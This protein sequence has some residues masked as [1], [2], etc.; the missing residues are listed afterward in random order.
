MKMRQSV[1][2]LLFLFLL[3][4]CPAILAATGLNPVPLINQPLAPTAAVPGGAAF[5]LTVN[6]TGFVSGSIVQWNGSPRATTFV[7]NSQLTAA[8]LASD[9]T[10]ATT[11]IVTVL[12]PTPG[13][14]TS[15]PVAFQVVNATS[16]VAYSVSSV[17]VGV[18]T[19]NP[20]REVVVGDFA[21]YGKLDFAT[22]NADNTISV[23]LGNGDGTFQLPV[24]YPAGPA[25]TTL[26]GLTV[27]DFNGDGIRD[28]A[29]SFS[30]TSSGVGVLLGNGDGTFQPVVT[31]SATNNILGVLVAADLNGDGKLDLATNC[32][33]TVCI[34]LGNGDGTF[35]VTNLGSAFTETVQSIA[36]GDFNLDGNLDLAVTSTQSGTPYL[37]ILLGNGDGTFGAPTVV[38][39][40]LVDNATTSSVVVA[41][42]NQDGILDVAYY[43]SACGPPCAGYIDVLEGV[44][45]G[46]FQS[47]L[48]V[49]GLPG[50]V[51]AS[52]VVGDFNADG[53]LDLAIANTVLL[54]RGD[55][56]FAFNSVSLAQNA[57]V[58]GD[59]NG[60]GMLDFAS[61]NGTGV[62]IQLE[63]PG[64]FTGY[65]S[66]W[67]RTVVAGANAGYTL[68]IEPL[69]GYLGNVTITTGALP[70]GV[71]AVF[72]PT[73]MISNSNGSVSLTLVTD[74]TT[75]PGT[76]PITLTAT[77]GSLVHSATITLVVNAQAGDFTGSIVPGS[78]TIGGGEVA[79]Y[80]IQVIPIN[81]FIGDVTLSVSGVPP[82]ASASFNPPVVT[83][84]SGSAVLNI[85][86]AP[87]TPIGKYVLTLTGT[88]GSIT[89]SAN[90]I[91]NVSSNA[92][93]TGKIAP[94][95]AAVV[96]GARASY[97]ASVIPLNGFTGNVTVSVSGLP[98]GATAQVTPSV[99]MHGSGSASL[100]INTTASTPLGSYVLT[101]T[102]TCGTL[103]H[104]TS[105]Q[106]NVNATPGDFGATINPTSDTIAVGG[107]ASY[108]INLFP[109]NG[110]TGN[111]ALSVTGVPAGASAGFNP[112][113]VI[114]GGSGS[115][116]LT[117]TTTSSV[118][119]GTYTL[120]VTGTSG[121]ITHTAGITLI[122]SAG[123]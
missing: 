108:S 18:T 21:G 60:D 25:G 43:Y 65:P 47:P 9:L 3:V 83:G 81:N 10:T 48:T 11:A 45:D 5:T 109:I 64:D 8:I 102:G 35:G 30:G 105:I 4:S 67:S 79:S 121:S 82:M 70:T 69:N 119:P 114:A 41:D 14:G 88:S 91:F 110:F 78:Q 46:T 56:T 71:T 72:Q 28:I 44:G 32:D 89:H 36:V 95:T 31:T 103:V 34:L 58:A 42:F 85:T 120:Y 17:A 80:A 115:A 50:V 37:A 86:A 94:T 77:S 54:G 26:Q 101:V 76:Y 123:P 84:G 7:S 117:V 63:L 6:G 38:D 93:F 118:T 33:A 111:V 73:N 13:G 2:V 53:I 97:T 74:P 12:S 19:P 62:Y 20:G 106:L 90:V 116:T 96:P 29:V 68:I 39:T 40:A 1:C 24:L 92:D 59:F 52:P 27:G 100:L 104:S 122:I 87:S 49:S 98:S 16:S 113:N 66:P 55:G 23:V 51:G 107:F 22:Q 75:L 57:T 99:V 15:N 61:P 112:G